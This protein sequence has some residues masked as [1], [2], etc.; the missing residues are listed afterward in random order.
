MKTYP[1]QLAS[2]LSYTACGFHFCVLYDMIIQCFS[3][4]TSCHWIL[5]K[6]KSFLSCKNT[7][8]HCSSIGT[9]GHRSFQLKKSE[10][11]S[12]W[13]YITQLNGLFYVSQNAFQ[14]L[15]HGSID[16]AFQELVHTM[17]P[18]CHA[19]ADLNVARL[20]LKGGGVVNHCSKCT[21]NYLLKLVALTKYQNKDPFFYACCI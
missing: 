17:F 8:E 1:F 20:P 21:G 4:F 6:P 10:G 16:T 7:T 9:I 14:T 2:K 3:S 19:V 11:H 12:G 15:L 13:L 18:F 5:C